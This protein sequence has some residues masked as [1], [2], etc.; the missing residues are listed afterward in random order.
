MRGNAVDG[1]TCMRNELMKS[2]AICAA[3]YAAALGSAF[4]AA[5]PL[6]GASPLL[7]AAAADGCATL[8][9]F[10][11]SLIFDN[12]SLYDPFWS[13][14]PVPVA[15]FWAAA[16]GRGLQDGRT[17]VLLVLLLIWSV[18]LTATWVGG[19]GGLSHEDWRYRSR[20][21]RGA[22]RYWVISFFGFHVFPTVMV[23]TGLLPLFYAFKSDRMGLSIADI[24][25]FAVSLAGIFIEAAADTQLHR[26]KRA[27]P[28]SGSLVPWGLWKHARHPNYLGEILV[29]AGFSVSGFA[30]SGNPALLLCFVPILVMFRTI[31][32]PMMERHLSSTKPGYVNYLESRRVFL[33]FPKRPGRRG[34]RDPIVP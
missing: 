13:V 4:L 8:V 11:F 2:R 34:A 6:K 24:P 26:F 31:S 25:G 15:F 1:G 21:S 30:A 3:A 18:R 16:G 29:W 10:L 28:L 20:R 5:A 7:T 17:L 23:F 32:V 27:A 14:A 12:T 19:W 9:V 33:P 22:V